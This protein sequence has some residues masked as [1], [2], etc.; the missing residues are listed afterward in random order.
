ML[1]ITR[2]ELATVLQ[3][4]SMGQ[5]VQLGLTQGPWSLRR[6]HCPE[7][8]FFFSPRKNTKHQAMRPTSWIQS[9]DVEGTGLWRWFWCLRI[10]YRRKG[11]EEI[12][13]KRRN[14]EV[15]SDLSDLASLR[16][17][18]EILFTGEEPETIKQS[19]YKCVCVYMCMCAS[20]CVR[21]RVCVLRLG[22]DY[23]K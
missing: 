17:C 8:G 7:R 18:N 20:V 14:S 15:D 19:F 2:C 22:I 5:K 9:R 1:W 3:I 12:N 6:K 23:T 10:S 4:V 11:I 13:S 16:A 21:A